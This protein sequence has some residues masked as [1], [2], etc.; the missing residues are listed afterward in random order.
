MARLPRLPVA[1]AWMAGAAYAVGH[2]PLVAA[3]L[4][5]A[6]AYAMLRRRG[7]ALGIDLPF[8]SLVFN[9]PREGVVTLPG[10]TVQVFN[11]L[12]YTTE[13]QRRFPGAQ[14]DRLLHSAND[15]LEQLDIERLDTTR[16]AWAT[17]TRALRTACPANGLDVEAL[18]SWMDKQAA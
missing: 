2:G 6:Y 13:V 5:H 15:L 10:P 7:V 1:A 14:H 12:R 16:C 3:P 18:L 11:R 4:G 9:E 8:G 17:L